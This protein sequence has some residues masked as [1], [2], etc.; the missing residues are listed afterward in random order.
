MTTR[1][2]RAVMRESAFGSVADT[3]AWA[4]AGETMATSASAA[5]V[6]E[7]TSVTRTRTGRRDMGAPNEIQGCRPSVGTNPSQRCFGT[8]GSR[9]D[10]RDSDGSSATGGLVGPV[11]SL[12]WLS[13][14]SLSGNPRPPE[15]VDAHAYSPH[16]WL[17]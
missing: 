2:G 14:S 17:S 15:G 8:D 5:K 7:S 6:A 3:W 10:R 4:P 12:S 11:V 16:A 13:P 1:P 9:A